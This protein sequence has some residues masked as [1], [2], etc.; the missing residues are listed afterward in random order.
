VE[1]WGEAKSKEREKKIKIII[2]NWRKRRNT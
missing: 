2:D 1:G